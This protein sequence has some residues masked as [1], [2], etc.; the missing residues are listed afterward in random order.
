[1]YG[2]KARVS[3]DFTNSHGVP[4]TL[5]ISMDNV[6]L[7]VVTLERDVLPSDRG[8]VS[9]CQHMSL[10]SKEFTE[11]KRMFRHLYELENEK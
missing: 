11:I 7:G 5:T 9:A 8:P 4:V 3:V 2:R 1:M 10:D 6:G